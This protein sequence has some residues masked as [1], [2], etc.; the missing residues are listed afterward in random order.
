MT[1]AEAL[2]AKSGSKRLGT[3]QQQQK[4]FQ[5]KDVLLPHEN[6]WEKIANA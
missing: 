2:A 4:M 3:T 6:K 5:V 1:K